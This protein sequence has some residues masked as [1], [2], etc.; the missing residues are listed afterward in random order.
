MIDDCLYVAVDGVFAFDYLDLLS[1][2]IREAFNDFL[3]CLE[4][5]PDHPD[6]VWFV[7]FGFVLWA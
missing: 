7:M 3:L 5:V 1:A 6:E 2:T 4:G